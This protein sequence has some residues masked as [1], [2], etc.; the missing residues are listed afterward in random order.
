MQ[1]YIQ[2]AYQDEFSV[3]CP[4]IDAKNFL[5]TLLFQE[6]DAP[7]QLRIIA[8][9]D[10]PT[11]ELYKLIT[12]DFVFDTH[13]RSHKGNVLNDYDDMWHPQAK[14]YWTVAYHDGRQTTYGWSG[15][16][17]EFRFYI[18]PNESISYEV[19][20]LYA[21]IAKGKPLDIPQGSGKAITSENVF[22]PWATELLIDRQCVPCSHLRVSICPNWELREGKGYVRVGE[23]T[24][25]IQGKLHYKN[26][27]ETLR[28]KSPVDLVLKDG[29]F[30]ENDS[31]TT[32]SLR[33]GTSKISRA[34]D[35][36]N[37][38]K[39]F[40]FQAKG[41]HYTILEELPKAL[42]ADSVV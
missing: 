8:S 11:S 36:S 18:T 2:I 12:Q 14:G 3:D 33:R 34:A 32:F 37:Y 38:N 7:E 35:Y 42:V 22:A 1:K 20:M 27:P 40:D 17:K 9:G 23:P 31:K 16:P 24:F 28:E 13:L 25:S 5:P 21:G 39:L 30:T 4:T 6:S 19:D 10:P 26:T 41:S 29:Y 15:I